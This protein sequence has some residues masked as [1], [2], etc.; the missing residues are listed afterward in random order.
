MAVGD[1]AC[2]HVRVHLSRRLLHVVEA[3]FLERFESARVAFANVVKPTPDFDRA[4]RRRRRFPAGELDLRTSRDGLGVGAKMLG[5]EEDAPS[6][7]KLR[8][9]AQHLS[10]R[11]RHVDVGRILERFE[12]AFLGFSHR[13]QTTTR[14]IFFTEDKLRLVVCRP[15]RTLKKAL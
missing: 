14:E 6:I 5:E 10:R 12:S 11:L 8:G 4:H 9:Q 13:G 1:Q 15:T 2:L 3:R 7:L